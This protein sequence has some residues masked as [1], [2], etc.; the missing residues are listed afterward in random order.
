MHSHHKSTLF[1]QLHPDVYRRRHNI[2]TTPTLSR[3]IRWLIWFSIFTAILQTEPTVNDKAGSLL[4]AVELFFAVIFTVEYI[5]RLWSLSADERWGQR[6]KQIAYIVSPASLTD[7]L[8]TA[9]LWMGVLM[10]GGTLIVAM[11]LFRC[12]RLI[13]DM[14]RSGSFA[15]FRRFGKAFKE[16]WPIFKVGIMAFL[17]LLAVGSVGLFFAEGQAQPEA[18]GSIPRAAWCVVMVFSTIGF[19]DVFPVTLAGKLIVAF[20][21]I[22]TTGIATMP[23]YI[24]F[25]A[26]ER[27]TVEHDN[28][29]GEMTV[30]ELKTLLKAQPPAEK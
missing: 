27:T 28:T 4:K 29:V 16:S 19:G 17:M 9:G 1:E 12:V 15:I 6:H 11:R 23:G 14:Q 20:M 5:A 3:V 13:T 22:S 18:F 24:L 25:S 21:A 7:I 8:A 2:K 26:F 10:S 30:E